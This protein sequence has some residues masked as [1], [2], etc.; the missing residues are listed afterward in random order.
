MNKFYIICFPLQFKHYLLA[1]ASVYTY[2]LPLGFSCYC[3]PSMVSLFPSVALQFLF[4]WISI[5]SSTVL[6]SPIYNIA[7]FHQLDINLFICRVI[8]FYLLNHCFLSVAQ[9]FPICNIVLFYLLNHCFLSVAQQFLICNIVLFYLL[10]HRFFISRVVIGY[11]QGSRFRLYVCLQQ[12]SQVLNMP[13]IN[14]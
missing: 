6:Q 1:V 10:N 12:S 8:V 11:Q 9:Q 14:A 4:Y 5:S 13:L 7:V 3:F 2:N